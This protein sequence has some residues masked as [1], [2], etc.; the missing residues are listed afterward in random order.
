MNRTKQLLLILTIAVA[1][2]SCKNKKEVADQSS[3]TTK[4]LPEVVDVQ[5]IEQEP[6]IKKVDDSQ[7]DRVNKTLVDSVVAR[8]Q[9]TA[10][11]GRCPI[12]VMTVFEGGSV[13]FEGKKWVEK[14]GVFRASV[15]KESIEKLYAKANEVGFF[16]MNN[17][18]DNQYVTDLPSTITTLKIKGEFKTV[19]AR[20]EAPDLLH[21]FNN[22]FDAQF[23]ALNWEK[24]E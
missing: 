20:Y 4:T 8:I 13:M 15:S 16:K 9:R 19:I 23:S 3:Q 5:P 7:I 17:I 10:C 14:E 24:V 6:E 11:F 18:Y 2:F 21:E 1:T 22:Y 12:Y